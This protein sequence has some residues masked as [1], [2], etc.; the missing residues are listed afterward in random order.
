LDVEQDTTLSN[1]DT[2]QEPVQFLI[3]S[4]GQKQVMWNNS[5]LLV[6]SDIIIKQTHNFKED[7]CY[8]AN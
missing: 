4:D 5:L 2:F 3:A 6:I 1:G 7:I 8:T